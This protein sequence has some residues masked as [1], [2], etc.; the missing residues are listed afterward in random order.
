MTKYFLLP[1][2]TALFFDAT[3]TFAGTSPTAPEKL[4]KA[5]II[6][7]GEQMYRNGILPSGG[8]MPA[9]I[10]GD[11]EVDSSVF[12]CSSCHLR[13]GLGSYEGGVITPPTTGL[14]LY[15]KYRRPPSLGDKAD[16]TGRYIYAKTVQERPPY[17][18]AT[19]ATALLV[20]IDPAG[21][22]FNDVMPRYP[23]SE[24]DLSILI[25]YLETLSSEPSPGASST[26]FKFATIISDDVTQEERDALLQPLRIFIER[27]NKQLAMYNDFLKFGFVPTA[28]MKYAFR[29]ASLDIWELK[30][31]PDSWKKQLETYNAKSPVFAILGGISNREW[32]PVHDF[33]EDER[34]PCLFPITKLPVIS[35]TGWYTYYFNKGYYQEGETAA[36]YLDRRDNAVDS[37]DI[38]QIVQDTPAGRALADGFQNSWT[39]SGKPP[40]VTVTLSSAQL[41][42]RAGL[43]SLLT[44]K[45][46]SVI[47]LW[48]DGNLLPGLEPIISRLPDQGDVFI[49]S[50]YFGKNAVSI[51]E[52]LRS[53]V[54]IT[55]P[56]RLTPYVGPQTGQFDA[57]VP[58]LTGAKDFGDN[59]ITSQTVTMLLQAASQGLNRINDNL[60]R[61]NLL[62][63]M[64]MQMDLIVKDFERLS[65]G[66]GQ[67]YVS[68][69]CYIIQL[70]PGNDPS[71]LQRSEWVI[72]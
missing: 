6:R 30:G 47:L 3:L 57:K 49:S 46:Y 41:M 18:R 58:L 52:K 34:I 21:Q 14:K 42:D 51:P 55:W 24:Y 19:L 65:F 7:L 43:D 48:S 62:D 63:V 23:L 69:G 9:Y 28:E 66:P 68:K 72:H 71:L 12:S 13:A 40:V 60:Y 67:R 33:C 16:Q 25:R 44:Q 56:Y 31:A 11:V 1:L 20:G 64:S 2:L 38:L 8:P 27:K 26:E 53:R 10:R 45:K 50:S 32:K 15:Q 17:T 5:E 37:S 4:P 35:E 29:R 22:T 70:G 61:D 54:L 59:R 36:H 39:E